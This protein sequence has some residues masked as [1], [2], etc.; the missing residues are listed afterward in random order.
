MNKSRRAVSEII[1]SL[2]LLAIT[3]VGGIAAFAIV[4][5]SVAM[6]NIN[7]QVIESAKTTAGSVKI[8]GFDTRDGT[9]L[10]GIT[11]L[12]NDGDG[13][14]T[15]DADFIVVKIRN[16]TTTFVLI[17]NVHINEVKHVFD[18]TVITVDA[19]S[20]PAAGNFAIISP[21]AEVT[22]ATADVLQQQDVR[23]VIALDSSIDD[24]KLTEG[25]RI[26]ISASGTAELDFARFII[27]AGTA[28]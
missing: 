15:A 10:S 20:R 22:F 2:V 16:T 17:N 12:D 27:P 9:G 23:L 4:T 7:E 21:S 6:Q 14:L 19:N 11:G 25:I 13:V 28:R 8:I 18:G 1:A 5:D 24:I 26:D 3:V